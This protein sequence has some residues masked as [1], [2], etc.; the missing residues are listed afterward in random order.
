M[1]AA[2]FHTRSAASWQMR[3]ATKGGDLHRSDASALVRYLPLHDGCDRAAVQ[4]GRTD[5][6]L[7]GSEKPGTGSVRNP[8]NG[9]WF[10]DVRV[11]ID[12]IDWLTEDDRYSIFEGKRALAAPPRRP[13]ALRRP[14]SVFWVPLNAAPPVASLARAPIYLPGRRPRRSSD[15]RHRAT[16]RFGVSKRCC[17]CR[18]FT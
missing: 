10:D 2:P 11:L 7:F 8:E 14:L 18:G 17:R 12:E 16:L 9:R 13:H 6:C 1:R 15:R 3:R 4:D 5:R